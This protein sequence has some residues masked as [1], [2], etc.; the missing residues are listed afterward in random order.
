M[1][2]EEK[3]TFVVDSGALRRQSSVFKAMLFGGF[4]ESDRQ[5]N[6]MVTLPAHKPGILEPILNI[7]HANPDEIPSTPTLADVYDML[8]VSDYFDV[9][10]CFAPWARQWY[11]EALS[12]R[13]HNNFLWA[14]RRMCIANDVGLQSELHEMM[15]RL[16]FALH[17]DADGD[18][19]YHRMSNTDK[20]PKIKSSSILIDTKCLGK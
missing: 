3:T 17:I 4:A 9:T 2:G 19:T 15:Q 1:V 10:A 12:L 8:L 16:I 6:W 7:I 5:S 14:I 11:Y 20:A 13:D 18:F